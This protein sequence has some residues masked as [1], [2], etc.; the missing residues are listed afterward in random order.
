MIQVSPLKPWLLSDLG[1]QI[2]GPGVGLP[3]AIC[4]P[5][6]AC[7]VGSIWEETLIDPWSWVSARGRALHQLIDLLPGEALAHRPRPSAPSVARIESEESYARGWPVRSQ[8]RYRVV[9]EV[10]LLSGLVLRAVAVGEQDIRFSG[11]GPSSL[12]RAEVVV[13]LRLL[14]GARRDEGEG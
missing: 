7:E 9:R 3:I 2:Q 10:C 11:F 5:E 6:H 1:R 14:P 4:L 12:E 13:E 8:V